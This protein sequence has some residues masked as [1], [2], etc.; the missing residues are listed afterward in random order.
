MSKEYRSAEINVKVGCPVACLYCPQSNFIKSYRGSKRVISRDDL[1]MILNNLTSGGE[2]AEVFFAAMAEPFSHKEC[3]EMTE[4]CQRHPLITRVVVF[5][6]GY[7]LT[8]EK[9]KRLS[10]LDK[11]KMNFHVGKKDYMTNLDEKI[12]SKIETIIDMMPRSEF[13]NVGFEK[14]LKL[15][16]FLSGKGVELKFQP[17]I[18]RAGNLTSVD[19]KELDH[20]TIKYPV[21]CPRVTDRK[22]PV[23]LPDGTALACANDY[24]CEL[25]IGNLLHSKWEDLDF[26]KIARMQKKPCNMP[27]F[28]NCHYA[29]VLKTNPKML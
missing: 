1:K 29:S 12:W 21:T 3:V 8:E 16:Q 20:T 2:E 5:T 11:L 24:S 4:D 13:I 26:E 19:G 7:Q 27:C 25:E 14:D 22:R 28:K 15:E 23:V 9:I 10:V 18:N 6:T 17:V